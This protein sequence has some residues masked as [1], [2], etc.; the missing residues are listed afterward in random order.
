MSFVLVGGAQPTIDKD[1]D[2]SL[3][4]GVDCAAVLHSGDALATAAAV[5]TGT[6][7]VGAATISGTVISARVSGGTAGVTGAVTFSWTTAGG[8]S[9]QRT[10]Y[11][12]VAER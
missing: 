11:L 2:A 12:R 4:Y 5:G 9:D 6:L 3:R 10:V 7:V 8:D 1:P